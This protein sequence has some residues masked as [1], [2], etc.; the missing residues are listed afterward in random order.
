MKPEVS[1]STPETMRLP[2]RFIAILYGRIQ[3]DLASTGGVTRGKDALKMLMVGAK[4]TQ[5]CSAL[6]RHGISYLH[7]IEQEMVE[8]MDEN[9]YHSVQQMQGSLSQI[10]CPDPSAF[11]RAQYMRAVQTF[12]PHHSLI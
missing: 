12:H 11:E 2:M 6:L 3:A 7:V 1:L 4:V 10:N 5:V 9:D 8:W